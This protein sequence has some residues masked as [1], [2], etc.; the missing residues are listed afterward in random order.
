MSSLGIATQP[1][2]CL[3]KILRVN[4]PLRHTDRIHPDVAY[5]TWQRIRV[6]YYFLIIVNYAILIVGAASSR[7][8][9]MMAK[10]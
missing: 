4:S 6:H 1:S 7:D 3:S 5:S 9:A 2:R 10:K 8:H